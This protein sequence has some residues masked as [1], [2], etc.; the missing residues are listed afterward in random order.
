MPKLTEC[1]S[2]ITKPSIENTSI[3]TN[4]ITPVPIHVN[5]SCNNSDQS[6]TDTSNHGKYNIWL[7]YYRVNVIHTQFGC[8]N[9]RL[10]I[11]RLH[12]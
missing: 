3:I 2:P 5:S 7:F 10:T 6:Q 8:Y 4:L 11:V 9:I 12:R 1:F